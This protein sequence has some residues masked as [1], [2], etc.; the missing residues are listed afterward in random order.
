[1][2]VR[3]R[4]G[5]RVAVM[6]PACTDT[7][8]WELNAPSVLLSGAWHLPVLSARVFCTAHCAARSLSRLRRCA[9]ASPSLSPHPCCVVC[10]GFRRPLL[11]TSR[12][13]PALGEGA[14]CP[15]PP[16][17]GWSGANGQ[18]LPRTEL[19]AAV[20]GRGVAWQ[21]RTWHVGEQMARRNR[22]NTG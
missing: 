20:R 21:V 16:L 19:R 8:R 11:H 22:I 4:A 13:C 14:V 6:P 18:A 3:G 17:H 1:M 7:W 2:T 9:G 12:L 10:Y 5:D 15:P